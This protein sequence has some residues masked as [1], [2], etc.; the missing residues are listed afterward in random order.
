MRR[1]R[2]TKSASSYE[3]IDKH[4]LRKAIAESQV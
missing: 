3:A 2:R 1:A 4:Q